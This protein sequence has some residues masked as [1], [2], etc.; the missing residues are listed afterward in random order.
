MMQIET[1]APPAVRSPRKR[2]RYDEFLT[3]IKQAGGNW[4][5]VP[6]EEVTGSTSG[7]KQTTIFQAAR[8]R[9]LHVTTTIQA[10]RLYARLAPQENI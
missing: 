4:A 8:T 9:G 10:G 1:C 2:N 6:V 7:R 5:S 3:A